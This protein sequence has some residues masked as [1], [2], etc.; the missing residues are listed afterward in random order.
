VTRLR[1]SRSGVWI[2]A[3]TRF[4]FLPHNVQTDSHAHQTSYSVHTGGFYAGVKSAG[5]WDWLPT[6]SSKKVKQSHYMERPWVFQEFEAPRFQVN[7][8]MKVVRLSALRTGRLYPQKTFLVLISVKRLSQPH[9]HSA[10]GRIMSMKKSSDSIGNRTRDLCLILRLKT[11]GYIHLLPI[12]AFKVWTGT[13]VSLCINISHFLPCVLRVH[14]I[15]S[16]P[17]LA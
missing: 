9:R 13:N 12:Y 3:G 16:L 4:F 10:A 7:Q 1:T 17:L 15:S 8:H 2:Q 5:T 6:L 14:P 11:C